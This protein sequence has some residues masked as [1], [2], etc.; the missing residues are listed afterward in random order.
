MRPRQFT[1]ADLFATAR[2][3]VLEHGPGVSAARIAEAMGVSQAALFKRVG[4]KRE[5]L[6]RAMAA[7]EEPEFLALLEAGPD[8]RPVRTQLLEYALKIDAFFEARMPVFAMCKAA[9]LGPED[10]FDPNGDPPPV[11][12]VR[13]LAA[14]FRTLQEQGRADVANPEAVGVAFLGSLQARHAMR[15]FMGCSYPDGGPDYVETLVSTICK[16]IEPSEEKSSQ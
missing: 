6:R 15:A 13:A 10:L 14:M 1:D 7:A 12:A 8:D 4:T 9:G 11:R 16:G 5:L 2:Q 3:L